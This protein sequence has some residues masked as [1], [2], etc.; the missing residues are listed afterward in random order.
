MRLVQYVNGDQI[1][2]GVM[3]DDEIVASVLEGLRRNYGASVPEP[4]GQ[5]ITQWGADPFARGS[6]SYVARG[7][8]Y[9][10]HDAIATPVDGVLHLAGEATWS[11]CPATV[12][13]AL[14]SGHRAAERILGASIPLEHLAD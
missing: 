9:A 2:V 4:T 6:Y 3:R 11:D 5:W 1:G 13:G 7:A 8:S 10:D 12:N 14:L